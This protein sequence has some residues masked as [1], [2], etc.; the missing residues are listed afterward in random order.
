MQRE[1]NPFSPGSGLRPPALEGRDSEI[2]AFDLLIARTQARAHNRGVVLHGLRGV[3]KTVLLNKFQEMAERADWFIVELEGR[4]SETGEQAVR[5][6]LG[7]A[8]VTAALKA[9]RRKNVSERVR[10]ALG[11]VTSFSASLGFASVSVGIAPTAGRGDS[12]HIE[13]DFEELVEDLAPAL[14]ESSTAFGL[15]ID[16]MQELDSELLVA[17]LAA[18]HRAG[19]KAWPFYI[20]AAGLPDLP[21]RLGDARSYAERLFDYRR[22]GPL[23]SEAAKAALL[24]PVISRGAKFDDDALHAL[25]DRS[26]GYPYFLQTF[27]SAAWD[28]GSDKKISALDAEAAITIGNEKL[29]M[30]FYSARWDRIS[31]AERRYLQAMA[32]L[33]DE[34]FHTRDVASALGTPL[35]GQSSTRH[36]LIAKGIV[37]APDRGLLAFT[38]PGMPEFIRRQFPD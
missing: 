34:V 12:G 9:N 28:A 11:T 18:Q 8:L 24:E 32:T 15:F 4:S 6:K 26:A 27:G 21:A 14:K 35:S 38:V 33:G 16:E 3:G 5:Q 22:I 2:D 36:S 23:T 10:E 30:G 7:R 20:I 17:L 13:I 29:D 1:L 19:Q 31:T 37:Y 25:M